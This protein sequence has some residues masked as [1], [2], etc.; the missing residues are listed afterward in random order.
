MAAYIVFIRDRVRD[1]AGYAS[2]SAV[3]APTI[4]GHAARPLAYSGPVESLEGPPIDGVIMIEFS[5][6]A[7][8]RAW[9][10]SPAYTA[11]RG[12]RFASADFRV[13]ITEG[14]PAA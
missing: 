1:L 2:Y 5:T 3:A 14:L 13:F 7:E 12:Q 10:D 4:A 9:Y 11:V 6:M 8:A